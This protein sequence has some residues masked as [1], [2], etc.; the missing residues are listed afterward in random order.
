METP[1]RYDEDALHKKMVEVVKVLDGMP[2]S[3]ARHVMDEAFRIIQYGHLVN[4][5]DPR[6]KKLIS[7]FEKSPSE[8]QK[9]HRTRINPKALG[10]EAENRLNELRQKK[11]LR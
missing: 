3:Q 2:I 10:R 11:R 9:S 4:L 8:S 1:L 5:D 6:L 7:E